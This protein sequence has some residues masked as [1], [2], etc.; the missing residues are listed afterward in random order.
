[1]S[2][3]DNMGSIVQV[4]SDISSSLTYMRHKA[5]IRSNEIAVYNRV[6]C[7]LTHV[8]YTGLIPGLRTANERRRYFVTTS[9]IGWAQA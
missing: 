9:L 4:T 7:A 6:H 5:A 3:I 2:L 8:T 1:M